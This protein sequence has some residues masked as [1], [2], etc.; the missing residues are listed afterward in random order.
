MVFLQE[1]R[2]LAQQQPVPAQLLPY[3]PSADFSLYAGYD[4]FHH[5]SF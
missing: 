2:L 1:C 4:G 5:S 3:E